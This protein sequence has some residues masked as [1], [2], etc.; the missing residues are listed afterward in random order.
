MG[1]TFTIREH[2]A[3]FTLHSRRRFSLEGYAFLHDFAITRSHLVLL[4]NPLH[5]QIWPFLSG[6]RCPIHCMEFAEAEGVTVHVVPRSQDLDAAAVEEQ[7]DLEGW[8]SVADDPWL[9]PGSGAALAR[10]G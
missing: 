6:Q 3:D 1:T 9:P 4:Q 10:N 5:L 2:N 7:E 8:H